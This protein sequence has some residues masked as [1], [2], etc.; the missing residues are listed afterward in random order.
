MELEL[1]GDCRDAIA[2]T[3]AMYGDVTIIGGRRFEVTKINEIAKWIYF[4]LFVKTSQ[5]HWKHW[6]K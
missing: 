3:N 1:L 2:K 5:T 6:R 4:R